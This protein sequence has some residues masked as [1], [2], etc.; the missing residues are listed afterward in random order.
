MDLDGKAQWGYQMLTHSQGRLV[1]QIWSSGFSHS[2]QKFCLGNF[3]PFIQIN[4]HARFKH[5]KNELNM[6]VG[7]PHIVYNGSYL[8]MVWF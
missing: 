4:T 7:F 5:N 1:I 6:D 8:T 3:L 2:T